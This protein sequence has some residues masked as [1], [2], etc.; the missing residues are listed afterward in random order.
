MVYLPIGSV[1][2]LKNGKKRV[3][4]YGRKIRADG[5]EKVYDYLGCLY[6][7][8]AL[9]SKDVV[10]FDHS[11]IQMVYFIGFQDLEELAFRSRLPEAGEG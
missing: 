5:E 3:M 11:Q 1:V 7:E 2:L 6:P 9:N 10:L 4:V 8:G